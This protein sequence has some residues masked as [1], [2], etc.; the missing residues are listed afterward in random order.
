MLFDVVPGVSLE[1]MEKE[2]IIPTQ[3]FA[4]LTAQHIG[5]RLGV[6]KDNGKKREIFCPVFICI[7]N[8]TNNKPIIVNTGRIK[9]EL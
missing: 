6:I 1:F 4:M 5:G 8:Q 7:A 3:L 9:I 2:N